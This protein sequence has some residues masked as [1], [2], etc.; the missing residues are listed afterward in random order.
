MTLFCFPQAQS[1]LSLQGLKLPN[2]IM[3][4]IYHPSF[5]PFVLLNMFAFVVLLSAVKNITLSLDE[6]AFL[7]IYETILRQVS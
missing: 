2:E 4:T 5:L 1:A 6:A 7:G 3:V